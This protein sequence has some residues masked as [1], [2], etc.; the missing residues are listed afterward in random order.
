MEYNNLTVETIVRFVDT[1]G[2]I[3]HQCLTPFIIL[4]VIKHGQLSR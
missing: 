4:S 2:F 3:Y 1:G